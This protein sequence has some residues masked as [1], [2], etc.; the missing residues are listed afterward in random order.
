MSL[1]VMSLVFELVVAPE[2]VEPDGV[3]VP[4]SGVSVGLVGGVVVS[5]LVESFGGVVD[6]FGSVGPAVGPAA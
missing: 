6:E 4:E 2:L 3:M 1:C 5:V